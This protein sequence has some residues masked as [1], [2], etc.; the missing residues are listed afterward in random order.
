M[1]LRPDA[2]P[3]I[4]DAGVRAVEAALERRG[5]EGTVEEIPDI[6]RGNYRVRLRHGVDEPAVV[7]VEDPSRYRD[8]VNAA[9]ATCDREHLVVLGTGVEPV[10]SDT[11]QELAAWLDQPGIAGVTGRV[12]SSGGFV[13]HAGMVRRPGGEPLLPCCGFRAD[14][15]GYGAMAVNIRNVS[16]L[17]PMACAW[18][19]DALRA[20]GG[21]PTAF[22]G[23]YA[24]L[25]ASV[26][27][28]RAGHRLLYNPLATFESDDP[29]LQPA[30]WGEA[31]RDL[32]AERRRDAIE[33]DLHFHWAFDRSHVDMRLGLG[34]PD[35]VFDVDLHRSEAAT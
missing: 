17:H 15:P 11:Y 27:A 7:R 30:M 24:I 31:E 1:A 21:L 8:V 32:F 22:E 10:A 26:E 34:A 19:V 33:H 25:D 6:W 23:A 14:D 12:L 5:M 35:Y 2:K 16:L 20:I 3:H 18:R 4:F 9:L 29:M 28:E 13:Q